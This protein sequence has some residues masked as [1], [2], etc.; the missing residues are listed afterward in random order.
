MGAIAKPVSVL[1]ANRGRF[2]FTP[3]L[4]IPPLSLP[5]TTVPGDAGKLPFYRGRNILNWVLINDEKEFG[6][7]VHY[8]LK[9]LFIRLQ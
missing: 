8:K 7:T 6:I 1:F 3:E 2:C 5:K 4:S 9:Y